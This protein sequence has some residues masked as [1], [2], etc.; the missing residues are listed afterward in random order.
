[1]KKY[2]SLVKVQL[3]DYVYKSISSLGLSRRANL[4]ILLVPFLFLAFS[5]FSFM[6]SHQFYT[7]YSMIGL[8]ELTI[9][10]MYT[11]TSLVLFLVSFTSIMG[12]FFYSN[13]T[14]FYTTL[15]VKDNLVV[16]SKITIQYIIGLAVGLVLLGPAAIIYWS[17]SQA[18][19]LSYVYGIIVLLLTPIIPILAG[20]IMVMAG[21]R[22]ISRYVSRNTLSI[23][24]GMI[25]VIALLGMQ[26]L[27]SRQAANIEVMQRYILEED[28][29]LNIASRGYPPSLWV[30]KMFMGSGYRHAVYFVL[31]N[32]AMTG[33]LWILSV[34][35][36]RKAV[37]AFAEGSGKI[38]AKGKIL[39]KSDTQIMSL[40]K[41]QLLI[42]LKTP[43]FLL[44]I[45]LLLFLPL[46][47]ILLWRASGVMD[48]KNMLQGPLKDYKV[49]FLVFMMASPSIM[50]A[51]SATSIT[52]EG[53][54]LWQVRTMPVKEM[55]DLHSRILTSIIL[56][57]AG[58]IPMFVASLFIIEMDAITIILG[59]M[60]SLSII[61]AF[62]VSDLIIDIYRPI[63]SWTNPT[64][65][66]KNNMNI[67]TA[68]LIRL[69]IGVIIYLAR[70]LWLPLNHNW[71]VIMLSLFMAAIAAIAY[72]YIK[73]V[74]VKIYRALEL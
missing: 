68:L 45:I 66:I 1:M 67:M 72:V 37:A 28:G 5:S 73:K 61:L 35:L 16:F 26:V 71:R 10:I 27:V 18:P 29:I 34:P 57:F 6:V 13:D 65:A 56:A 32:A 62:S 7:V 8:P 54:T 53:K 2:L 58:A 50:G 49:F 38:P 46:I 64:Y 19:V 51:F 55:T 21:M 44:N 22:V 25:F 14:A 69:V 31:L 41:R 17:T 43:T 3:K 40:V 12:T 48:L 63:L 42:I 74:G 4:G 60:S 39:Y 24:M 70:D 47:L 15:P 20:T 36:F 59:V 23:V 11:G 9:A 52:R 30:A 33:I